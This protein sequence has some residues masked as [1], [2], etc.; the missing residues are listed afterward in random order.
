[1][2]PQ[3][4]SHTRARDMQQGVK[5]MDPIALLGVKQLFAGGGGGA[6]YSA[7]AVETSLARKRGGEGDLGRG[8]REAGGVPSTRNIA[9]LQCLGFRTRMC[10][11]VGAL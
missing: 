8:G 5:M 10:G 6:A 3:Q 7:S 2:N 9:W 11:L 1:M 4:D